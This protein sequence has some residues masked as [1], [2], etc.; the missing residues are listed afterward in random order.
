M[1][2]EEIIQELEKI[3]AKTEEMERRL[4]AILKDEKNE[5]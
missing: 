2:N 5:E 3:L 1:E 4:E